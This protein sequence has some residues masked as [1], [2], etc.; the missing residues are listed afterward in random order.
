MTN[1]KLIIF[2]LDGT[3]FDSAD[4]YVVASNLVLKTFG[5]PLVDRNDI[6]HGLGF[7]LRELLI[8]IANLNVQQVNEFQ[9]LFKQHYLALCTEKVTP[10]PGVLEFLKTP[11][12]FKMAL[13][14]NKSLEPTLK[15]LRHF[16]LYPDPW[17][18]VI[19]FDSYPLTK[20]DPFAFKHLMSL[21][22]VNPSETL[23]IGDCEPDIKGAQNAGIESVGCLYGYSSKEKVTG[24]K[25][26]YQISS[27]PELSALL[28]I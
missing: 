21:A 10:Y 19:G 18:E 12:P 24:L 28:K 25:P 20:P 23:M 9:I 26:T 14:T 11:K 8:K 22:Q 13:V 2:D 3:L 16:G 15:I 5:K 1:K 7:G 4:D 17:I 27:F 6:I